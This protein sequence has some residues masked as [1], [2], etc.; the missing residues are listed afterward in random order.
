MIQQIEWHQKNGEKIGF[1]ARGAIWYRGTGIGTYTYQLA[2]ELQRCFPLDQLCFFLPGAEYQ[3]LDFSCREQFIPLENKKNY[4]SAEFLPRALKEQKIALYHVP[5]NGIG[6]PAEKCCK[7]VVTIHD[8]IPYIYPETVGKSYLRDFL[9]EMPRVM[10]L[11]DGIITVSQQSKQD[12]IQLF[13]Y[14]EQRIRVI[15]EAAEPVYHLRSKELCQKVLE[16][17]YGIP[18]HFV[19]YVGG[20]GPRKNLRG[21]LVAF[22]LASKQ[23]RK[24]PVLVCVGKTQREGDY[25]EELIQALGLT[26]QVIFPGYI[27]VEIM[28][29]F[30]GGADTFVYPSIYEGFGLPVLE[31]MACGC[32]V[33][34]G[35]NSSLPEVAG[36]AA[37]LVDVLQSQEIAEA[38]RQALEDEA[39]QHDLCQKGLMQSAKFSWQKNAVETLDFYQKMLQE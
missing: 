19:L 38:I 9:K 37:I 10:A 14:P 6:L 25:L 30:Y 8:L 27:P 16:R 32:P 1:D 36:E 39:L 22:A 17:N 5:Q 21:L 15:P 29:Y 31:A 18:K 28:P 35:K 11:A 24:K 7:L 26:G 12:I 3:G 33:I 20:F 4:W 34:T 2:A 23:M 13:Q